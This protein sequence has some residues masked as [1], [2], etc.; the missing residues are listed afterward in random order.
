MPEAPLDEPSGFDYP[1]D[2]GIMPGWK[3]PRP[4]QG[5]DTTFDRGGDAMSA[6]LLTALAAVATS[7]ALPSESGFSISGSVVFDGEPAGQVVVNLLAAEQDVTIEQ[8]Y[9][10]VPPLRQSRLSA[11]G[12]YRFEGVPPGRYTVTA[13]MDADGDGAP[14]FDPPEPFGWNAEPNRLFR[15]VVVVDGGDVTGVDVSLRLPTPFPKEGRTAD[16]GS[17]LWMKGLPV[18]RLSG[19]AEERGFAHGYLVGPQII[20]FFE[21][22]IIE[23]MVAS[24]EKYEQVYYPFFQSGIRL[25]DGLGRELDAVVEGMRAAGTDMRVELLGREFDRTDLLAINAYIERRA[26]VPVEPVGE[27]CSQFALWGERT[28]GSELEGGLIAGRNMDGEIDIRKVT[29]SHFLVFAVEPSEPGRRRWVSTMW[30]G[31]VGTLSGVN[32]DGLYSM[33]DAG[34]SAPGPVVGGVVPCSWIQRRA[35]ETAGADATAESIAT[36]MDEFKSDAG[37]VT[38]AGSVILWAVPYRGQEAPAF[39]YE[40]ERHGG[41]MRKPADA[42]PIDSCDIMGTNHYRVYG[43]DPDKGPESNFGRPVSCWRYE[44]GMATLEAWSRTGRQAG[45]AE[46]K[47]LLQ[48][49]A[50]GST[51]HSVIFL[52]NEMRILIA[53]DDLKADA[54]DAPHLEWRDFAFEDLFAR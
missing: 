11:P 40:G 14:G 2:G 10:T 39:I 4:P 8:Y 37:G 6:V 42:R 28:L 24:V 7:G 5:C 49:V 12:A 53:R 3:T 17:L 29:V 33:E 27:E 30:P 43:T 16:H 35:L 9:G 15:D 22:Y 31:F 18:L 23:N 47:Q 19:T 32:E 1:S 25:P 48:N 41:L 20:D 13:F 45:V 52:A 44:T 21:F 36:M 34:P 26:A 54:W 51:E 46:M 38:A 50:R